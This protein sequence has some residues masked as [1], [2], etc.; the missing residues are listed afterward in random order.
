MQFASAI[1]IYIQKDNKLSNNFVRE[2]L[3]NQKIIDC[4]LYLVKI[5]YAIE[6]YKNINT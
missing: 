3:N 2:C 4:I 6:I 1:T 5:N